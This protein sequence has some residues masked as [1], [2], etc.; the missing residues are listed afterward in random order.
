M[1]FVIAFIGALLVD[2]FTLLQE[3][4]TGLMGTLLR[5]ILLRQGTV[6]STDIN[7]PLSALGNLAPAFLGYMSSTIWKSCKRC[8]GFL[9]NLAS[10][11]FV[12]YVL[13]NK[14]L[15]AQAIISDLSHLLHLP[16]I[17]I[18]HLV[19][20]VMDK[21]NLM[22]NFII[23]KMITFGYSSLYLARTQISLDVWIYSLSLLV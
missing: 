3:G 20:K 18:Q 12:K 4:L 11:S 8:F 2:S 5:T 15:V 13:N 23:N 16:G 17:A 21:F 9:K 10:S 22:S 1:I 14:L 7:I 6:V 19:M